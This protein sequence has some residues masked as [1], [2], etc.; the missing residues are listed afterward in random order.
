MPIKR[1]LVRDRRRVSVRE[2]A[3]VFPRSWKPDA[4]RTCKKHG[5]GRASYSCGSCDVHRVGASEMWCERCPLLDRY[6]KEAPPKS[7]ALVYAIIHKVSNKAYIGK[8]KHS[9]Q[10]RIRDH[11]RGPG[12]RSVSLIHFAIKKYGIDAFRCVV[13][14]LYLNEFID[15]A[16]QQEIATQNT[17]APNG[18]NLCAGGEGGKGM[19]PDTRKRLMDSISDPVFKKKFRETAKRVQNAPGAQ[20][21]R[22]NSLRETLS[23]NP[24]ARKRSSDAAKERMRKRFP[25]GYVSRQKPRERTTNTKEQSKE[26]HRISL[27]KTNQKK[28]EAVAAIARKTALPYEPS[29]SKRVNGSFYRSKDG[30]TI[31]RCRGRNFKYVC[32]V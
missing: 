10:D 13:L 31:R 17:L 3:A 15:E 2:H 7:H 4:E 14:G 5:V 18:Y 27:M 25:P 28:R 26:L 20:E 29:L 9:L 23:T 30:K 19:H 8:T 6:F 1:N 21:K 22:I 32:D 12:R 11:I 24:D 16:E